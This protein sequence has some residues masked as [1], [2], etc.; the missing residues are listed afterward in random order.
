VKRRW[1]V[2]GLVVAGLVLGAGPAQASRDRLEGG[3]VGWEWAGGTRVADSVDGPKSSNA[4]Q[5]DGTNG[6]YVYL[7]GY[8]DVPLAKY[9]AQ[10]SY[11]AGGDAAGG[12]GSQRI[13]VI[14]SNA[15]VETGEVIYLDPFHCPSAA[16]GNGWAK[17][18]FFR[19]GSDCTIFTSWNGAGY[20]GTATTSAWELA[21]AAAEGKESYYSFL[22]AD[23][24]GTTVV[25]RVRFG[26]AVLSA[27][28][29]DDH[30]AP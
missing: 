24:E 8:W 12:D 26:S 15:G 22:I 4:Y 19:T 5:L 16:N 27:F 21:V 6:S 13:S 1:I 23:W 17:T 28:H 18:D 14:L 2:G 10:F 29:A 11:R 9:Q 3:G 30:P 7:R 25:D 20:T